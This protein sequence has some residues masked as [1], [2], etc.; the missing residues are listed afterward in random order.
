MLLGGLDDMPPPILECPIATS[1]KVAGDGQEIQVR[2]VGKSHDQCTPDPDPG[3]EPG[4]NPNPKP[5]CRSRP[6]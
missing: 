6:R 3:P 5:N 2:G 1:F 4:P